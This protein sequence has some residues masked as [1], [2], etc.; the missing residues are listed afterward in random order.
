MLTT[1]AL[2]SPGES[3]SRAVTNAGPA[4]AG[5]THRPVLPAAGQTVSVYAR[6]SDPDDLSEVMLQVYRL[7]PSPVV[8]TVIMSSRGAGLVSAEIPAQGSGTLAAFRI[9]ARDSAGVVSAF[10]ESA[11][12]REGLI[13][14]GDAT[15]PGDLGAYGSG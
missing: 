4:I 1:T 5:V 3:N 12:G 8:R 6:V 11:P 13:R 10:P 15:P 14:W 7:D 9:V 2:G